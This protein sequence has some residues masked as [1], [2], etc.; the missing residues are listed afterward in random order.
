MIQIFKCSVEFQLYADLC[1]FQ[2]NAFFGVIREMLT[3]VEQEHRGKLEQLDKMKKEQ[4]Y[5]SSFVSKYRYI[6]NFPPYLYV[7]GLWG[8][9]GVQL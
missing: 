5:C 1:N 7:Y 8:R 2:F 4:R 9:E 3:K 6:Y